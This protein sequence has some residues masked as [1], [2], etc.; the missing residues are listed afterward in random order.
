MDWMTLLIELIG[1]AILLV[2][3]V[4]PVQEFRGIL[5]KLRRQGDLPPPPPPRGSP[6]AGGRE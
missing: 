4:I 3:V 5:S 2:F 1:L 6:E